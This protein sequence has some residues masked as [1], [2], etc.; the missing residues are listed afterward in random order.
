MGSCDRGRHEETV[1]SMVKVLTVLGMGQQVG[2]PD[3]APSGLTPVTSLL[4]LLPQFSICHWAQSC[5]PGQLP[6]ALMSMK[7][8]VI[9]TCDMRNTHVLLATILPHSHRA[10]AIWSEERGS[11][12]LQAH[13]PAPLLLYS[14]KN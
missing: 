3:L 10:R 9:F 8:G 4:S 12:S 1:T 7:T 2:V 6:W 14:G 11:L 13:H 5:L